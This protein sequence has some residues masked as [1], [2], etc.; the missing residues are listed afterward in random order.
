VIGA[1]SGTRDSLAISGTSL[2]GLKEGMYVLYPGGLVGQVNRAGVG[3]A[4]VRLVD[5]PGVPRQRPI[6]A[7]HLRQPQYTFEFLATP[8]VLAEGLV[9]RGLPLSIIGYDAPASP[10]RGRPPSRRGLCPAL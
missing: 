9:V 8:T 7:I 5:R 6:R 4:Q 1:D 2:D 10:E 3:G